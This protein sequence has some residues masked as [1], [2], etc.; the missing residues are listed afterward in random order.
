[1]RVVS[2]TG[3]RRR[4]DAVLLDVANTLLFLDD[5]AVSR[6]LVAV[7][8]D[9]SPGYLRQ[10][11][12]R[13]RLEADAR[14]ASPTPG[15]APPRRS[16]QEPLVDALGIVEADARA[17]VLEI[18]LSLHE[19]QRL[20]RLVPETTRRGLA[21]LRARGHR[22]AAVSNADGRLR[23]Q[24][25]ATGLLEHFEAIA[26]SALVGFEK[27]DPRIFRHALAALGIAPDRAVHAGD[28]L[29]RDVR[30]AEAAGLFAV[31][32]DEDSAHFA[33]ASIQRVR[34]V[35]ELPALLDRI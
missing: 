8:I 21:D 27:P 16:W 22:L 23:E 29:C 9:V 3:R 1:M 26:D 14:L 34:H 31:L 17:L 20:F 35:G 19:R 5:E 10:A 7:G 6:E 28:M 4:F 33:P 30:G 12:R 15:P 24:L 25:E 32:V 13:A 11:H 2:L 18:L